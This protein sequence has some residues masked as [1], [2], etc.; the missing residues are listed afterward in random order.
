MKFHM[1]IN[2]L[3]NICHYLHNRTLCHHYWQKIEM[4]FNVQKSR[5]I[6]FTLHPRADWFRCWCQNLRENPNIFVKMTSVLT[7][8]LNSCEIFSSL[9]DEVKFFIKVLRKSYG[10]D[11]YN[12]TSLTLH[13]RLIKKISWYTQLWKEF[14]Y[15]IK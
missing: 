5:H 7:F 12:I 4:F 9:D 11:G 8:D 1:Y 2:D 3:S 14:H 6:I 13:I 10:C 15:E